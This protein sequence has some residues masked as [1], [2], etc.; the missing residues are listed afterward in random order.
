MADDRKHGSRVIRA[1]GHVS[2]M[3]PGLGRWMA[4]DEDL[5]ALQGQDA[6]QCPE[7]TGLPCSVPPPQDGQPVQGKLKRG[8]AQD[9][10]L[11]DPEA[12]IT[13]G[14]MGLFHGAVWSGAS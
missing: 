1:L 4:I 8:V 6:G 10:M 13:A 12:D 7:E 11:P 3:M 9:R 14:K 5:P 2:A